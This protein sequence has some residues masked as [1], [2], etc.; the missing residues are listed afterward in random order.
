MIDAIEALRRGRPRALGVKT[1][2]GHEDDA[3][4]ALLDVLNVLQRD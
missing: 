2:T 1:R 3:Y 4:I